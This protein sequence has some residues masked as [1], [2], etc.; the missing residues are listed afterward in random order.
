MNPDP[1]PDPG[2]G[3]PTSESS[4]RQATRATR[5]AG[6]LR[7]WALRAGLFCVLLGAALTTVANV[8]VVA[9]TSDRIVSESAELRPAQVVIVP[10]SFVHSDGS[11]GP[12]VQERVDAAVRLYEAGLVAKILVS[13][14]H[15][16]AAYNEPD[17]MREALLASRVPAK[18][19]FTDHAGF[20]TWHTMRRAREIFGVETA[21]VVTQDTYAARSVD[22]GWAAGID[23]QG[24][25]VGDAGR[26]VRETLARVR[27]IGE[28]MWRPSVTAG[29]PIPITGDGRS[30]WTGR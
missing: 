13:G 24:Y 29:E 22:L 9:R 28:A 20:S 18:D 26:R 30:S 23:T 16:T 11:L 12:V 25:V 14:D 21:I 8:V 27:G 6:Q 1:S 4:G 17:A 2:S 19:V 7:G 15:G 3:R 10:G 5:Y